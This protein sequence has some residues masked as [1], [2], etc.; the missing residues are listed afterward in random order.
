VPPRAAV[1]FQAFAPDIVEGARDPQIAADGAD[2]AYR[3]RPLDD[4]QAHSVYAL[5]EGHRSVLPQWFPCLGKH[6]GKDR[7]DGPLACPSQ[8][9]TLIRV[10]TDRK[11]VV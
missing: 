7:A 5:V 8:L 1:A 10:R 2:V 9:S 11:S 4:A 6:S 3:L